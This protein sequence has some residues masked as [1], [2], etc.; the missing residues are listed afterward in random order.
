MAALGEEAEDLAVAEVGEAD[1]AAVAGGAE[2]AVAGLV[3]P[4]SDGPDG[5]LVKADCADV[6]RV[7]SV[8]L[9]H[10]EE[11]AATVVL[12]GGGG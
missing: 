6:P 2:E 3:G 1:G 10:L 9:Q 8:R 11:V 5:G 7:V 4:D 12:C